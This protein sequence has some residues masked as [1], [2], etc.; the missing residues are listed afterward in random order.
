MP[1]FDGLRHNVTHN[2]FMNAN[3]QTG[4]KNR[5]HFKPFAFSKPP[6][7]NSKKLTRKKKGGIKKRTKTVKRH[8]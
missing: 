6:I 1:G 7:L 5:V 3:T 2:F 4:K 8:D